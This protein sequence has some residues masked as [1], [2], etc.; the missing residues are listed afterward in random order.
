VGNAILRAAQ[1]TGMPEGVFSMLFDNGFSVG[2]GLVKHPEARAVGFT[3]SQNGGLSLYRLAQE[4]PDPIPVFAEMGSVNPVVVLPEAVEKNGAGLAKA[5]A[6]S[7]TLGS[8]QFCTN[9]GLVFA[10]KSPALDAFLDHYRREIEAIAPAP[11]LT[12]GIY[13]HFRKR[14]AEVL[15]QKGVQVLGASAQEAGD[16]HHAPQPVLA[17]TTADN[18]RHNSLLHEEVFGPY[19]LLV[20]CDNPED[21][22]RAVKAIGGQLT[23]TV[24]SEGG[25]AAAYPE[26]L[27]AL[28]EKAGRLILNGVP[29]GV[30]VCPAMQHGGPFPATTDARFTSVG[31]HAI[32][33][34]VRPLAWQNWP[35]ELLPA[36]LQNDNPSQIW[37]L[38]NGAWT[39]S[40]I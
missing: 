12:Q 17:W 7:V 13:E 9:P 37:R 31:T 38:V 10:M 24:W 19:S 40:A 16:V 23:A 18:F 5:L 25:E 21:M 36:E 30:E 3:G 32:R 15:A 22:L 33:R 29:T 8:G 11:M 35:G 4:R 27:Q 34:W 26:L 6:G 28:G 39:K 20:I 2:Q 14:G 1:R